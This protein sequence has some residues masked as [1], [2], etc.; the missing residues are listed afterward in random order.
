MGTVDFLGGMNPNVI[1]WV[2]DSE[3]LLFVSQTGEVK[4]KLALQN[5][6]VHTHL[7]IH[8]FF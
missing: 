3:L 1:L 2:K 6:N 5:N 8:F 4:T 7:Y